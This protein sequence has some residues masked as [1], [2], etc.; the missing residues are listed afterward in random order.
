M[1]RSVQFPHRSDTGGTDVQIWGYCVECAQ[2]FACLRG[3]D[4]TVADWSCP[5]CGLAPVSVEQRVDEDPVESVGS[6]ADASVRLRDL[7]PSNRP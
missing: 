7:A 4:G 6:V 3:P 1:S 2:W 5:V